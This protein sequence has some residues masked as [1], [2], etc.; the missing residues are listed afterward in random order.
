MKSRG[1]EFPQ[2]YYMGSGCVD[3]SFIAHYLMHMVGFENEYQRHDR[4][5]FTNIEENIASGNWVGPNSTG[6]ASKAFQD[7]V[8]AKREK[9]D[10]FSSLL[11]PY[12]C[13]SVMH[14]G[15]QWVQCNDDIRGKGRLTHLRAGKNTYFSQLDIKKLREYSCRN[16]QDN[17]D[18]EEY[19]LS[20]Q[21][22][23]DRSKLT[24][25]PLPPPFTTAGG[26]KVVPKEGIKEDDYDHFEGTGELDEDPKKN[27]V[28]TSGKG[29]DDLQPTKDPDYCKI[30]HKK[31]DIKFRSP[32]YPNKIPNNYDCWY[33]FANEDVNYKV[34]VKFEKFNLENQTGESCNDW[35]KLAAGSFFCARYAP[36]NGVLYSECGKPMQFR[37]KTDHGIKSV[38]FSGV[39]KK[40]ACDEEELGESDILDTVS[41]KGMTAGFVIVSAFAVFF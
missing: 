21:K 18:D 20:S 10:N 6:P 37:L 25:I 13:Y 5:K 40:V 3:H 24:P 34:E 29:D 16:A 9:D 30:D 14:W 7:D 31:G 1:E 19:P 22:P 35:I 4:G 36:N 38:G 17:G 11:G 26:M 32:E 12:D 23:G 41:F 27:T 15:P 39:A 28:A 8:T 2:D 33:K